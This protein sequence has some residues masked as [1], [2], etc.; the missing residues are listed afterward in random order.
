MKPDLYQRCSIALVTVAAVAFAGPAN[1]QARRVQAPAPA[2]P[3]SVQAPS[4]SATSQA[5][6]NLKLQI[7]ALRNSVGRQVVVLNFGP[8]PTTSW[9]NSDNNAPKNS[10]RAEK[11]CSEAL[12]DRYGQVVSRQVEPSADLSR[13]Y[14]PNLVCE[15]K[16]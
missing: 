14:F 15:T 5:M 1:A 12:G 7:E 9:S 11:I 16:P 3:P 2:Q 13:W 4:I 8:L 10:A 6:A